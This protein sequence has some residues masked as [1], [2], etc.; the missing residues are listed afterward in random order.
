MIFQFFQIP[1]KKAAI[2]SLSYFDLFL[3][4]TPPSLLY[5]SSSDLAFL[6]SLKVLT[7]LDPSVMALF[8]SVMILLNSSS[9]WTSW[10]ALAAYSSSPSLAL[11]K[12]FYNSVIL[13]TSAKISLLFSEIYLI[14]FSYSVMIPLCFGSAALLISVWMFWVSATMF[15]SS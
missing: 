13:E 9:F 1:L 11:N 7:A 4:T 5:S 14:C 8:N 3:E 10:F 6:F 15:E 2:S 12:S